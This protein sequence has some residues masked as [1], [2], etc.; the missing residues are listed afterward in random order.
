MHP[1]LLKEPAGTLSVAA[2]L[3]LLAMVFRS[4]KSQTDQPDRTEESAW[5]LAP[6]LQPGF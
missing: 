4:I 2:F 5:S 1:C 3:Q 6:D